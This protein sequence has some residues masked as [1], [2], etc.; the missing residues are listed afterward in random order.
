MTS[1]KKYPTHSLVYGGQYK[2]FVTLE[3]YEELLAASAERFNNLK[4][5]ADKVADS[6]FA[7]EAKV[8]ELEEY[9]FMYEGLN[10]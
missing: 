1:D 5:V 3:A 9:K 8:G 6:L 10:K 2:T 4:A 7:A